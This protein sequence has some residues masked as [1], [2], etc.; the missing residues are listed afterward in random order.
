[1]A[2]PSVKISSHLDPKVLEALHALQK[3]LTDEGQAVRVGIPDDASSKEE[4]TPLAMIGT[5]HEFGLPEKGIPE[6]PFLRASVNANADRYRALNKASLLA[7]VNGTMT[8]EQALNRL[9]V[10]ATGDVKATIGKGRFALL[11]PETIRRKGS[12]KPLIDTGQMRQ[13]ITYVITTRDPQ[14]V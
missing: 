14:S 4:G 11:D 3:R 12:S 2:R 9:G 6:R 7:I 1:M 5:V 13:S 10:A 8:V